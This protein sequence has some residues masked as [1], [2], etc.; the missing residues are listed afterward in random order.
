[1]HWLV[2]ECK[3]IGTKIT[4]SRAYYKPW[5]HFSMEISWVPTYKYGNSVLFRGWGSRRQTLGWTENEERGG[6]V[7]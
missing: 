3:N 2:N 6:T 4:A 7:S 1:M 5:T